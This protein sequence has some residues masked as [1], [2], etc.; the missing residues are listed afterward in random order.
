M[1]EKIVGILYICTGKYDIFWEGFY[2]SAEQNFLPGYKKRYFV[3]T[4]AQHIYAEKNRNVLKIYQQN[5]GWPNNTLLRFEIFLKAESE[6]KHCDYLFYLNANMDFVDVIDERILPGD[7]NEGLVAVQHPGFWDKKA[8]DFTYDRN[9]DS[10]AY[11]QTGEGKYYFMGGFNGGKTDAYLKLIKTLNANIHRDLD[12]NIVA[13]WHD[14]SHLNHYLLDKTPKTLSPEYGYPEG[15]NL[16]FTPKVLIRSKNKYGGNDYLRN[17]TNAKI[18][19]P[20]KFD[21]ILK[22]IV[23]KIKKA[24][25][26]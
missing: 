24:L 14:E 3:F 2:K 10:S 13:L 15:F 7:K 22:R 25:C 1:T 12:N 11:I 23:R 16:P 6:F 26:S 20:N 9:P 18:K 17:I 8:L 21:N 19:S 5:L 4:D